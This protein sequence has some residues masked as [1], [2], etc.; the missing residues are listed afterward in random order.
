V[1]AAPAAIVGTVRSLFRSPLRGPWLTAVLGLVL[2]VGITVVAVTGLLSY[3]AYDPRLPGNDTTPNHGLT[4]FYLFD[5]PTRPSW[6]YAANQG[7]HVTLGIMLVPVLLAKLWSVI[8]RLFA[9][10]PATSPAHA[11]ERASVAL[12]VGAGLFEFAT[13]IANVQVYYPFHFSFYVGH[14]YGAWVFLSA[15]VVHAALKLPH[16]R[17]ALQVRGALRPLLDD[18][19][20]TQPEPPDEHGLA[21]VAPGAPTLSRRGLLGLVGGS[22][23]ALAL[24]TVGQS[25]GGPL[26]RLAVLAPHGRDLG[27]DFQVNKTA[28]SVGVTPQALAGWRLELVGAH[29]MALS[30]P[31]LLRLP[32]SQQT[33]PIACVEGWSTTQHW[34]GV[35]LHELAALCGVPR[36]SGARVESLQRRGSF[37]RVALGRD[38]VADPRSLLALRV[39]GADL[40]L[41]HGYPARIM[42]PG[43]PGVHQTKWVRRITFF[44]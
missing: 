15:F 6:L 4:G 19:A 23:L 7:A 8:P 43:Q 18:L 1:R 35:P 38:Q 9:W 24:V 26:R 36:P 28:A 16:A 14:F 25:V 3:A 2:L 29:R 22:S 41:D 37:R 13:G 39:N 20:H 32:R 31:A 17:R 5:W 42:V 27:P 33:L 12:L 11:L 21:P 40:T 10:P 44:A 30:R 34:D